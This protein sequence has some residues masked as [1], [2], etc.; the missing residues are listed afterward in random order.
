MTE[1]DEPGA[2]PDGGPHNPRPGAEVTALAAQ[3]RRVSDRVEQLHT[4]HTD[5]AASV[6]EQLGPDLAQLREQVATL[7]Q[8]LQDVLDVLERERRTA[9]VHWPSLT[10]D[11]ARHEWALLAGWVEEILV[12]W[13]GVTRG[14]LPDC[15]ALHRTAV[16]ELSW[17]RGT[18]VQAYQPRSPAT[19]PAE[20]HDRWRRVALANIR[21]AIPERQCAPG[22]HQTSEEE[23]RARTPPAPREQGAAGSYRQQLAERVHWNDFYGQAV[24]AD[25]RWRQTRE[26]RSANQA[27]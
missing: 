12:P 6:S 13:Y 18:Y 11:Q 3:L 17:W 8:Q 21:A 20:W 10:A 23:L 15:W 27:P 19:L 7:D 1:Q 26:E 5:L 25:L 14:E 2:A 4:M 24:A 16:V 9:P 22:R